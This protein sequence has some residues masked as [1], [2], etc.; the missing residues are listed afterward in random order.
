M[1]ACDAETVRDFDI[2]PW[3]GGEPEAT[4]IAT[5]YAQVFAEPPYDEDPAE[6]AAHFAERIGRYAAE[7]PNFRLLVATQQDEIIGF[8]LGT[9]V[10]PGDWWWDRLDNVLTAEQRTG[11]LTSQMFSVA[12]LAIAPSHRRSGVARQLMSEALRGLPYDRA[13]LGCHP[14]AAPAQHLY[15]SL[16]WSVIA[17]YAQ[18]TEERAVHVMGVHLRE[19]E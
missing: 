7:K 10:G 12:E 1:A 4:S 17:P 14:E 13:I 11:W 5:L 16:G 2:R 15:G 19:Q 18:V 8:V 3:D 6:N 9:G